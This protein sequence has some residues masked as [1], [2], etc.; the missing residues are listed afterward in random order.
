LLVLLAK[1]QRAVREDFA[2]DAAGFTPVDVGAGGA[3]L[4]DCRP[5]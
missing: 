1:I 3:G 2:A 5:P 4:A